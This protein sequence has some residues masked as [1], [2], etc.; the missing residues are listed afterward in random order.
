MKQSSY[1]S[2]RLLLCFCMSLYMLCNFS[3]QAQ[4]SS[5]KIQLGAEL[6]ALPYATGGYFAAGWVGKERIRARVLTAGVH[7][8]GFI[9]RDGFTN[10]HITSYAVIADYFLKDNWKGWWAGAGLVYWKSS[11]QSDARLQTTGFENYLLN[12]SIGYNIPLYKKLYLSPWAGLSIRTAG[13]K[14]VAVDAKHY[15]LALLNPEAS[16]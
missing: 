8:P 12:G 16:V 5:K 13:D 14:N 9:T 7:M 10:H 11:I 15:T 4:S 1:L 3:V 2:L 6:D